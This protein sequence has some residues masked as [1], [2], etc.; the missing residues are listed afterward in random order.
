MTDVAPP[1]GSDSEGEGP[2]EFDAN[3][4][5]DDT[6]DRLEQAIADLLSILGETDDSIL[7]DWVCVAVSQGM[8][9]EG[10]PVASD[11][12]VLPKRFMP[13]HRLKGLLVDGLD[14]LRNSEQIVHILPPG[15]FEEEE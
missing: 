9:D 5:L 11:A 1:P 3:K 12:I 6:L 14:Q 13:N 2:E 8:T 10:V 15:S 7:T 4:V